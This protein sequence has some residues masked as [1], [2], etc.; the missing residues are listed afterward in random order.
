MKF[1]LSIF[2]ILAYFHE[3]VFSQILAIDFGTHYIKSAV[4]NF[5]TGKSFT[6]VENH[7]SERKFINS[8]RIYHNIA[9]L[10]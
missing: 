3:M 10:L 8:V 1:Q 5:G 2:L 7:K 9:W 6:V 4:V